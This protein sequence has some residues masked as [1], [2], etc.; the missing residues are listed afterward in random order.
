MLL[1]IAGRIVKQIIYKRF[2][3]NLMVKWRQENGDKEVYIKK[4]SRRIELPRF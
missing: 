3:K 1:S 4:T 2:K